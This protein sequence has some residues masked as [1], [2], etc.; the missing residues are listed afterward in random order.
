MLLVKGE[1]RKDKMK[2]PRRWNEAEDMLELVSNILME[3]DELE[4]SG[5]EV[6]ASFDCGA[7][8][9]IGTLD[10]RTP[11]GRHFRLDLSEIL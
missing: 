10:I 6:D 4:E 5:Y 8:G 1:R 11:D 2:A 3:S 9:E 7:Y